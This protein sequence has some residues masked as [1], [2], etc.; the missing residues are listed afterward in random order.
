[1]RND[2]ILQEL[3]KYEYLNQM[4]TQ[5]NQTYYYHNNINNTT[6]INNHH[7]QQ[8]QQEQLY[9]GGAV[10]KNINSCKTKPYQNSVINGYCEPIIAEKPIIKMQ[11]PE[12]ER[13]QLMNCDNNNMMGGY[14]ENGHAP[15]SNSSNWFYKPNEVY[16][17]QVIFALLLS[18]KNIVT[19]V[20][21]NE[22]DFLPIL[23][24]FQNRQGLFPI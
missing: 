6:D 24:S 16:L 12:I 14:V 2:S 1:M 22:Q 20:K 21:I 4:T 18:A 10:I 17:T 23:R 11:Q 15:R 19:A 5:K 13:S 3:Q 8:Q 7:L 9:A